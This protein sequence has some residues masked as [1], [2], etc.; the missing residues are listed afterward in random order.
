MPKH[1]QVTA[2][3]VRDA[4]KFL[5]KKKMLDIIPPRLFAA[6]AKE[7]G[8]GLDETLRYLARLQM[9]GQGLGPVPVTEDV[10]RAGAPHITI[11]NGRTPQ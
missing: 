1:E 6:S 7:T 11:N 9:G 8:Q 4:R 10:V 3:D 5:K 2:G